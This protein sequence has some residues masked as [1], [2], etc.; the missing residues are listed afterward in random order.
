VDVVVAD[1]AAHARSA[2]RL[3]LEQH[4]RVRC[5]TQASTYACLVRSISTADADVLLLDW[6]LPGL[7]LPQLRGACPGARI[8]VLC[9]RPEERGAALAAGADA[10][11]CKGDAPEVLLASLLPGAPRE[12]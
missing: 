8:I 3:L 11:V 7:D 1:A 12:A 10:F 4:P 2:L 6:R 5:V 9:A